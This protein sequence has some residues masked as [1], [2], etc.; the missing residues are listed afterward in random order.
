MHFIVSKSLNDFR[1]LSL[2]SSNY[3]SSRFCLTERAV[4]N[5]YSDNFRSQTYHFRGHINILK[6]QPLSM[7]FLL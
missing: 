1:K 5:F 3:R 6:P 2:V 7:Q 4:V